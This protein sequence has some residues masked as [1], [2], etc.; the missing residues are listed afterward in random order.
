MKRRS[1][2][3]T[4]FV[5]S[6]FMF[7]V[8]AYARIDPESIAG[9]WLLDEGNGDEALD[10]SGNEQ[11]G[12][13]TGGP[14]WVEGV[15]GDCLEF[16]GGGQ[17]EIPDNDIFNFGEDK[18]FSAVLWFNFSTPQ[19]WNRI[20]RE[21]TPGAWA[22]GNHGWEIQTQQAM[23]HW[24]LDDAAGNHMKTTYNNAGD[25][26]WHH[27]AM[28]VDR[29]SKTMTSYLDGD[30]KMSVNIANIGSVADVLPITIAGG[31][32]GMV[33]E[34]AIFSDI[35]DQGDVVD[36][37]NLGLSA[38]LEIAEPVSPAG[39]LISVWASIKDIK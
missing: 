25:G 1:I 36:I 15:F 5:C 34:L 12:V 4:I 18:N 24:S 22:A 28:I 30:N 37:M 38:A 21:R 20:F 10:S 39:S 9:M 27:T 17:V 16:A 6:F 19:D 7:S 13:I 11:H 8:S 26:E 23:V 33:D 32:T 3:V 14:Q 35:I 31:F 29:D 2:L